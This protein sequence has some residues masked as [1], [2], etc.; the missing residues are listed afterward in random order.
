[1]P[2]IVLT[3]QLGAPEARWE[4]VAFLP[5]GPE[6]HQIGYQPEDP[7]HELIA[8]VPHSVAIGPDRSIWVL[9][10]VK[11][12]VARFSPSGEFLGAV[13][14]RAGVTP[15]ET[16]SD[17]AFAGER[18]IVLRRTGIPW[19]AAA[20][21][22]DGGTIAPGERVRWLDRAVMVGGLVPT[23]GAV[24]GQLLGYSGIGGTKF[25]GGPEGY[26]EI[27][28]ETGEASMLPG[29]PLGDG[30]W[31]RFQV[32]GSSGRD[33]QATFLKKDA[34]TVLPIRIL[35]L[36]EGGPTSRRIPI[37]ASAE[38]LVATEHG[39][40]VYMTIGSFSRRVRPTRWYLEI[41]NDGSPLGWER[42]PDP[43]VDD[44]RLSRHLTSGPNDSVYFI[45][46]GASGFTIYR[47][48][49]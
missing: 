23:R 48:P 1:M 33:W 47:R 46:A 5:Y 26:A 24:V 27:D 32:V 34:A 6:E 49:G 18:L 37:G 10:H 43:E 36:E 14:L 41:S 15:F 29:I 45:H 7:E 31:M 4:R 17:L 40:A 19:T 11:S 21:P 20:A 25:G 38:A 28:A 22:L 30:T 9:D 8:S 2:R 35:L 3:A 12:R 16:A 42:R 13:P 44:Q 39:I